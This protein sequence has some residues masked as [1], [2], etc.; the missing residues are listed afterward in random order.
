MNGANGYVVCG[1]DKYASANIFL[2]AADYGYGT[3]PLFTGSYGEYSS[4]VPS[5]DDS[6]SMNLCLCL[7]FDSSNHHAD[8][9]GWRFFGYS[10]RP[11]QGFAK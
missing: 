3:S 4:S 10:V 8:V 2:P 11:V 1:R 9:G 6:Y 5:M 7:Y